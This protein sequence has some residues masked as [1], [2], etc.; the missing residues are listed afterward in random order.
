MHTI[1]T[2]H[3]FSLENCPPNLKTNLDKWRDFNPSYNFKYYDDDELHEWMETQTNKLIHSFFLKLNSGAGKADLFRI[4]RLFYQGGI[5]IDADLPAFDINKQKSDFSQCLDD[6]KGILVRNRKCDNPRY[7][8]IA[9]LPNNKLFEELIKLINQHILYALKNKQQHIT[10]IHITGPFV[11]HKLLTSKYALSDIK[12][13]KLNY[14]YDFD[15]SNFIYINDIVP[16][17]DNY[18]DENTYTGYQEDLQFMNVIQHNRLSC[19]K[20]T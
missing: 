18:V 19:V 6:N 8:L 13:L 11:L 14:T 1:F 5:W 2:S 3:K 7:T 12:E 4:C 15:D 9:S 17:R 10:T 20:K 16:E